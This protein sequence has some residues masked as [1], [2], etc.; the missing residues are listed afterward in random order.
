MIHNYIEMKIKFGIWVF[1]SAFATWNTN[2]VLNLNS[3]RFVRKIS[4]DAYFSSK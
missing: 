3:T 4:F 2:E 1:K